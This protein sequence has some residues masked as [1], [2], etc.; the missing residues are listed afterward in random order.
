VNKK[1]M[2]GKLSYGISSLIPIHNDKNLKLV[3]MQVIRSK[4]FE[5]QKRVHRYVSIT[6]GLDF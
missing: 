2:V 1:P 6:V 4:E 5:E 3:A